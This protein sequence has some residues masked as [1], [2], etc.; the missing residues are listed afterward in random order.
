MEG[1][2]SRLRS[3]SLV[4]EC[5][6]RGSCLGFIYRRQGSMRVIGMISGNTYTVRIA[7]R[8]GDVIVPL[9]AIPRFVLN[10]MGDLS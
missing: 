8:L 2:G 9:S 6:L 4:S 1:M 10:D 5:W 7:N 3:Q